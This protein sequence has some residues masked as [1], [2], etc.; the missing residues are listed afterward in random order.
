[1]R[2]KLLVTVALVTAPACL[3]APHANAV[4]PHDPL[5]NL[6]ICAAPYNQYDALLVSDGAGGAIIVWRDT[7]GSSQDVYA[8]HVDAS[9]AVQWTADGVPVCTATGTQWNVDIVSDGAGGVIVTWEDQRG[10]RDIYAQRVD[11][12]GAAMWTTDGVLICGAN[13]SQYKPKITTDGA[14]GA[15]IT[16]QDARVG[17]QDVYVQWINASGVAQWTADGL[18]VCTDAAA[19]YDPRIASDGYGGAFIAWHDYRNGNDYDV[20]AQHIHYSGAAGMEAGGEV[21]CAATNSQTMVEIIG[22]GVGGAI[23]PWWDSRS[24]IDSDIYAQRIDD[25]GDTHWTA[26]GVAVCTDA[27][28]QDNHRMVSDGAVGV[29]VVWQDDRSGF[30][31]D[32]IYAQRVSAYG[33]VEWTVDGVAVCSVPDA[34]DSNLV[35]DGS[36]GAIIAWED[37]RSQT[38]DQDIYAQKIER[39]GYLGYPAPGISSAV[40]HPDDQGGE[41][42]VSWGASYLDEWPLSV[43]DYYSVWRRYGGTG[44]LRLH[45]DAT[46]AILGAC[47]LEDLGLRGWIHV[48]DVNAMQ[49]S[50]YGYI[51]PSFG[52]STEAG[53]IWT[54]LI[55]LAHAYEG[56]DYWASEVMSGYSIDN[57]APGAPLA[58]MAEGDDV[59][60]ELV[61]SP[62]GYRDEDLGAYNVY[63]S[64]AQGFVADETTFV[65]AATDTVFTDVDPGAA[66]W[67][68]LVAGEDV[69]GNEGLPSNEASVTLG[70]GVAEPVAPQRFALL[71]NFPN[72]FN[73][74]TRIT[75]DLPEAASVELGIYTASG[76]RVAT[77]IDG[78]VE[79]G[80]RN[81]TWDGQDDRGMG[82]PSGIYFVRV[83]REGE[84]LS[85]KI[86]LL[87]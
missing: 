63:R 44:A 48:D 4:W 24:G 30:D 1:M 47:T 60:V 69:H 72:P 86:V 65:G 41:I 75:F 13:A 35:A 11:A 9:G 7:R 27:A 80:R 67:Y 21:I 77:L 40:D 78:V 26:D 43:V 39:S 38:S 23:I 61:W 18:V 59:D 73:P 46:S 51:A 50:E 14:G 16:W 83:T 29:I 12:S 8:Q 82:V 20:Y 85:H 37:Y 6:P 84:T 33:N 15:I 62:S 70:T 58:L 31:E 28:G 17:N 68:Y 25:N 10:V 45:T 2:I 57:L 36:G 53:I 5:E 81:V 79:A 42:I 76:R 71:G 52:D 19:Q 55:V 32:D 74:T 49:F 66:T 22:D 56:S 54:D 34:H 3:W 64:D 87:K